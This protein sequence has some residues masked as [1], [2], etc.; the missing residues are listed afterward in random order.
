MNLIYQFNFRRFLS[1][2]LSLQFSD[3]RY[4]LVKGAQ[5]RYFELFW[6]CTKLPLNSGKKPENNSSVR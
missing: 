6:P 3:L 5:S 1:Y 4:H 2:Q